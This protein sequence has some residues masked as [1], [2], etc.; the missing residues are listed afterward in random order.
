MAYVSTS[1]I[2]IFKDL[3]LIRE[4]DSSPFLGSLRPTE[5]NY[6][7]IGYFTGECTPTFYFKD[8]N[9]PHSIYRLNHLTGELKQ[10]DVISKGNYMDF[11]LRSER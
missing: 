6:D 9:Y 11:I 8:S 3:E 5:A 1:I 4:V 7:P 10:T 2:Y